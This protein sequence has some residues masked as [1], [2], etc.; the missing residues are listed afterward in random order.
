MGSLRHPLGYPEAPPPDVLSSDAVMV[1][2]APALVPA[3]SSHGGVS[4][5]IQQLLNTLKR[6]R[7][8]SRPVEDYYHDDE[9]P[10]EAVIGSWSK[11]RNYFIELTGTY[12]HTFHAHIAT[13]DPGGA[14]PETTKF[15]THIYSC[16]SFFP[17]SSV[18]ILLIPACCL[19][20][21]LL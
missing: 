7:K 13:I 9:V 14:S 1:G 19:L 6:P 20:C 18:Q 3:H 10:G 21:V 15:R 8:T 5:K 12:L 16:H 11:G 17:L 4:H 2:D